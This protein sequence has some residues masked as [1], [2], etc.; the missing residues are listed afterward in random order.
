MEF[1][2]APAPQGSPDIDDATR[3]A[4]ATRQMIM[5]PLHSDIAPDDLSDDIVVNQHIIQ[6]PIAN[7]GTDTETTITSSSQPAD[8]FMSKQTHPSHRIALISSVAGMLVLGTLV[9]Y[10]MIR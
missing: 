2:T 3:I 1:G 9:T 4:A 10:L 6:P 8:P 5:S 7:V